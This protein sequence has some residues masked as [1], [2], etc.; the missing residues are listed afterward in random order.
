[1][2]MAVTSGRPQG[3]LKKHLIHGFAIA[4]TAIASPANAKLGESSSAGF[5]TSWTGE[6]SATPEQIWA[7][8]IHPERWWNKS[9]S[10]SGNAANFSLTPRSGGCFCEAMPDK[11]FVEHARIINA[12]PHQLLRLSGAFGPLQGEALVGTLSITIKPGT[13]GKS[14]ISFDYVVGGYSRLPLEKIAPAVDMV[15]GEQHGRLIRLV[16]TGKAD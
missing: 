13:A 1:M 2:G 15:M 5:T 4:T 12:T 8:L 11:G 16:G 3:R 10:W 14:V 7:Q 6:V 9:H